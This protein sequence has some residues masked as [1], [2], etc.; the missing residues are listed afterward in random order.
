MRRFALPI[1]I[2]LARSNDAFAPK[3]N[4]NMRHI[5][6][7]N[8]RE[9]IPT[10]T[11]NVPDASTL[12]TLP[13]TALTTLRSQS[14]A[15]VR[16]FLAPELVRQ[17]RRDVEDLR[18]DGP[19]SQAAAAE[20]GSVDWFELLPSRPFSPNGN[21]NHGRESLYTLVEDLRTAI[22]GT[23]NIK[24]DAHLTELK[25]AYYVRWPLPFPLLAACRS[26]LHC[27][28]VLY[29]YSDSRVYSCSNSLMEVI[30]ESTL[31][32]STLGLDRE[33]FPL[34]STSIMSGSQHTADT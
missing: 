10:T 7:Y 20:H 12:E 29:G 9:T 34:F 8:N 6:I 3:Q 23:M 18:R 14:L 31:M 17:L 4:R 1:F 21:S 2:A 11:T 16:D 13:P 27:L 5:I 26:L 22:E 33:N 19:A 24:V 25:Y 28:F 30:T 15:I 32:H